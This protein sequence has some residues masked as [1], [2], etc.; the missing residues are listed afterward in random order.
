MRFYVPDANTIWTFREALKRAD[1]IDGL[2]RRFD[3]TLWLDGFLAKRGQIVDATIMAAPL[4]C[5][6]DTCST[7]LRTFDFTVGN[8][9][10]WDGYQ[11]A[12]FFADR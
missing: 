4:F 5:C 6:V 8:T 3:E 9:A 11:H 12:S 7:V 10:S 2:F 1:A